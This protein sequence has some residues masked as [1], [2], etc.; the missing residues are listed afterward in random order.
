[1]AEKVVL[2]PDGKERP[3]ALGEDYKGRPVDRDRD[4]WVVRA[5]DDSGRARHALAR[6]DGLLHL[7]KLRLAHLQ[8]TR[9]SDDAATLQ[10]MHELARRLKGHAELDEAEQFCRKCL[11][12]RRRLSSMCTTSLLHVRPP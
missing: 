3:A 2:D 5:V 4:V 1:M 11:A 8:E 12:R 10:C 6:A 9:G 7:L